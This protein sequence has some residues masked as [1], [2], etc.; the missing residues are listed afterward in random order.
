MLNHTHFLLSAGMATFSVE[1]VVRGGAFMYIRKFGTL[2][3]VSNYLAE[4]I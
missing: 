2:I 3:L 1:S 4:E